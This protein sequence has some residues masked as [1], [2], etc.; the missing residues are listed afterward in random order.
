MLIFLGAEAFNNYAE[1]LQSL[2]ELLWV[3]RAGLL[4]CFLLHVGATV[5]LTVGNYGK[6]PGRYAVTAYMGRKSWATRVMIFSGVIIFFFLF[7][8]INDFTL[9]DKTGAAS[10]LGSAGES[11]GL[12]GLVCNSFGNPLRA[13]LYIVAVC[14]V[15]LHFS[16]AVSSIWVTLGI[17][18]ERATPLAEQVSRGLG[19][20]VAAAFSAVPVYVLLKT[21]VLGGF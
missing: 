20:L 10:V 14:S 7:I 8:H 2:G 16:H 18:T 1:T 9:G 21:W 3:I 4:T 15:G 5:Y 19:A 11:L 17:L 12:Y 13:L 6:R